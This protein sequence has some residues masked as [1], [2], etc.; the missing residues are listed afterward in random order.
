M[1][2]RSVH[3]ACIVRRPC[4]HRPSTMLAWSVPIACL[5]GRKCLYGMAPTPVP[6]LRK[7]NWPPQCGFRKPQSGHFPLPKV[8]FHS[9][10]NVRISLSTCRTNNYGISSPFFRA[11]RA[12]GRKNGFSR[13]REI[14]VSKC[15]E[16]QCKPLPRQ[17]LRHPSYTGAGLKTDGWGLG[18]WGPARRTEPVQP[19]RTD[20]SPA[21]WEGSGV[22]E[23]GW[24]HHIPLQYPA[25][26]SAHRSPSTPAETMPP[27]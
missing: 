1:Q 16:G 23:Y 26:A 27:A 24:Q 2:A 25:A 10:S 20:F 13:I 14:K 4:L 18:P 7:G 21:L 3:H 5:E 12:E 22:F 11:S 15:K 19:C 9:L 17:R 8:L 6:A